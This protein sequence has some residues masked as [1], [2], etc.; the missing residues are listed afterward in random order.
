MQA[1]QEKILFINMLKSQIGGSYLSNLDFI[2]DLRKNY[3]VQ[4]DEVL[5]LDNYWKKNG[6]QQI[7]KIKNK[8]IIF[9]NIWDIIAIPADKYIKKIVSAIVN[10][11]E[12]DCIGQYTV[13]LGHE[14]LLWLAPEFKHRFK[15]NII[16]SI[17]HGT[18][19]HSIDELNIDFRN[20]F[21]GI[22]G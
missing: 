10:N 17:H 12:I 7:P 5:I 21:M 1:G 16:F 13:L 15:K 20:K 6:I 2:E 8:K 19:T 11:I 22:G 9:H 4:I 18:P 3:R 14:T